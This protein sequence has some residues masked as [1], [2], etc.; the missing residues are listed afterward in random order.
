MRILIAVGSKRGGTW[1]IGETLAATLRKQGHHVNLMRAERVRHLDNAD[2]AIVGGALYA[3]RWHRSARRLV[4]RCES[5]LRRVPVWFFSSGPLDD[6]AGKRTLAPVKQVEILMERVGARGHVTFGGRLTPDARGFP[7]SAM[8]KKLSG[9]WRDPERIEQWATRIARV[10]PHAKPG[11]VVTH[12]GRSIGRLLLHGLAGWAVCALALAAVL[13]AGS[14][15]IAYAVHTPLVP[16]VFALVAW[17][18]FRVRGARGALTT[19]TLFTAISAALDA[20]LIAGAM[21]RPALLTSVVGYCLPLALAFAVTW[22]VGEL[23]SMLPLPKP[24][25]HA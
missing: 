11:T 10:L 8:A 5:E 16:I 25:A 12:P 15:G 14:P 22:T 3:N 4:G 13:W 20:A 18:Y 6:S 23:M 2:A 17:R 24:Q 19:A 9:D 21:H 7:A 1:G